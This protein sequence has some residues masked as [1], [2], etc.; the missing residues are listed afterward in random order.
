MKNK[1]NKKSLLFITSTLTE[2][3]HDS[4]SNINGGEEPIIK[5]WPRYP[6]TITRPKE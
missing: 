1:N 4:L 6:K 3:T 5:P 2:L